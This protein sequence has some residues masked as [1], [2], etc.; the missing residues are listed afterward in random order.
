MTRCYV[1]IGIVTHVPSQAASARRIVIDLDTA[2]PLAA[3]PHIRAVPVCVISPFSPFR[4]PIRA[5]VRAANPKLREIVGLYVNPPA[6][7][8]VL[9]VDEKSQIQALDRTQPGC[10]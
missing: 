3:L 4:A 9:S 8:I 10:R 5:W 1:T 2:R 7:A 6:H